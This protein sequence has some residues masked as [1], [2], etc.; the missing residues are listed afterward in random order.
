MA[1]IEKALRSI[2]P[3]W[4]PN[5]A[6]MGKEAPARA[7]RSHPMLSVSSVVNQLPLGLEALP[8]YF[9]SVLI[10]EKLARSND[11]VDFCRLQL[12]AK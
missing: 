9:N 10:S 4:T 3:R 12:F 11:K 7:G 2:P 5:R 1:Q 8:R 6:R